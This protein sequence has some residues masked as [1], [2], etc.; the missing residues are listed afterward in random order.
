MNN[1]KS[2]KPAKKS[3]DE[4]MVA[5]FLDRAEA[6]AFKAH[7]DRADQ[8]IAQTIRRLIRE[9]MSRSAAK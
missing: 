2:K 1:V 5:A 9:E 8:S 7:C 3:N 4:M 6:T